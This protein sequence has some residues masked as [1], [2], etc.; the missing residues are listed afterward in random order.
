MKFLKSLSLLAVFAILVLASCKQDEFFEKEVIVPPVEPTEHHVNGLLT[1][2]MYNADGLDLGCISIDFPFELLLVNGNVVEIN[3]E[4]DFVT[5]LEDAV[6]PPLDFVYPLN[7]TDDEGN[8]QTVGNAEELADLFVDCIPD[9]GWDDDFPEWF[10]P[11]WVISY[12]TSCYQ[13]SYPVDLVDID[14]E[15][16][17][18]NDEPEL[19]SLLADGNIYSFAFPLSLEDEDGNVVTA[20]EPDDLFDLLSECSPDPGPGGCGVGSFGCYQV[21]YPATLLLID[22]STIEVNDDNEFAEVVISGEWAGFEFPLTLIDEDGNEI[23]VN[24]EN[25][26][27][28]AL[29]DCDPNWGG[30]PDIII[31]FGCYDL[32]YPTSILLID[33][34]ILSVNNEEELNDVILS[35]NWAGFDYPMTLIDEDGN[36]VTINSDEELNDAL[37]EC[38]DFGGGPINGMDEFFCYSFSYPFS[39]IELSTGTEYTFNDSNDWLIY[40]NNPVPAPYDFVFPLTLIDEDGNGIPVTDQEELFEAIED[41]W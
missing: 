31:T 34:S 41:C 37:L 20:A 3:T 24:D 39:I 12:E 22:G 21:G 33:G 4:A 32:G 28:D 14:G 9:T 38:D 16:I 6:N 36:E 19:I 40:H 2:S 27:Q 5:A 18:A 15:S 1:R 8:S 11:A 7:V 25:E 17:T 35:G 23:I 29:L 30:D 26:L 13:L 10:F